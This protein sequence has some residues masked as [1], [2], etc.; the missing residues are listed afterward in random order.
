MAVSKQYNATYALL[1]K[2]APVNFV[3][4]LA[5]MESGQ[6]PKNQTGKYRGLLQVGP[7]NLADYNKATK[8][9]YTEA[10]LFIPS[11]NV[12]IWCWW[13][14][15]FQAAAKALAIEPLATPDW[16]NREYV[17]LVS[18][19]W[20]AGWS[21]KAGVLYMAK[22]LTEHGYALT[23]ENVVGHAKEAGASKWLYSVAKGKWQR[24]V[25]ALFRRLQ[26]T[27]LVPF[28]VP[29][30]VTD[31]AKR[32]LIR[33]AEDADKATKKTTGGNWAWLIL[34]LLIAKDR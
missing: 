19:A 25:A 20:N 8:N 16:S 2:R 24:E 10:D 11:V 30:D 33:A 18:Q 23:H 3:R 14:G 28:P 34:I 32:G 5:H 6:N 9:V 4:A 29:E 15:K 21:S 7:E 12:R 27:S 31:A 22:W 1:C 17:K 13:L 26:S